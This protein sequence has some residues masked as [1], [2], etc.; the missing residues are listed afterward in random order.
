MFI[1][2]VEQVGEGCDYSIGCG[3]SLWRLEAKTRD[4]AIKELKASVLGEF[5]PEYGGH[6]EGYWDE[7]ELDLVT[8]FEVVNEEVISVE[9]WYSEVKKLRGEAQRKA[10]E[11]AEKNEYE[12]LKKIYG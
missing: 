6:Q 3:K 10:I 4:E 1:A 12:R 11:E 7:R 8:L 5:D 2:Y 9:Q